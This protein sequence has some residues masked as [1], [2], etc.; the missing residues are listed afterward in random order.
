MP[1]AD[2]IYNMADNKWANAVE[3]A[4]DKERKARAEE[5]DTRRAW[6]LGKHPDPLKPLP[7]QLNDNVKINL[8]GRGI[9]KENEFIG[10]PERLEVDGGVTRERGVDGVPT[11][12]TSA[13]QDTIDALFERFDDLFAEIKLV[14]MVDG[15][16]FLK[17]YVDDDETWQYS[18]LDTRIVTVYWER[19]RGS[20]ARA[21][22]Y[23]CQWK[24]GDDTYRQD[25]V[26]VS[27][28]GGP[29]VDANGR[30]VIDYARGWQVID[31]VQ[32]YQGSTWNMLNADEWP[33]PFPPVLDRRNK[34]QP[35][36]YYGAP[37]LDESLIELNHTANFIA[38]NTARIIKF[39]AHPRT[40]GIGVDPASIKTTSIDGLFTTPEG[41]EVFN[42]EMQSDL[43]SSMA[44]LQ[45][46]KGQFFAQ[47]RV[48]DQ[49]SIKDRLGQVTN[50]GLRT[51]YSDQIELTEELR[52]V[53]GELACEA[54]ARL[55]VV[56]NAPVNK[57]KAI[58]GDPLPVNRLELLQAAEIELRLGTTSKETLAEEIGRDPELEAQR[59]ADEQREEA[60]RM[61]EQML[62]QAQL[63][64]DDPKMG[65]GAGANRDA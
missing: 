35:F 34:S 48:V 58:W 49:S 9:D 12:T 30:V 36:S 28:M 27:V 55:A 10:H 20:R 24:D 29:E 57:P 46:V 61:D 50:F 17:L 22:W 26:P 23:R 53:Y 1:A 51:L 62:R 7:D 5:I 43:G 8:C 31:Y 37:T 59:L 63:G 64:L 15:H 33:Y 56:E 19:G 45:E 21:L 13:E 4:G 47:L 14:G 54:V 25:I 11:T 42:L 16:T 60:D 32:N 39:H 3:E 52:D 65:I 2:I 41:A 18:L 38:S 40:I 44:F 6:Y